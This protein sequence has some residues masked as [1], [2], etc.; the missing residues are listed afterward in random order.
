MPAT[1]SL[2][3]MFEQLSG[4]FKKGSQDT[5][6]LVY[7]DVPAWLDGLEGDAAADLAESAKPHMEEISRIIERLQQN[8]RIL[9]ETE[10][11]G[12]HDARSDEIV[13]NSLIP[14]IREISEP[15]SGN[16]PLN[17]CRFFATAE[18]I[19]STCNEAVIEHG[20]VLKEA[21]PAEI[22]AIKEDTHTIGR[23]LLGAR[24][25]VIEKCRAKRKLIAGVK[26][27]L[28]RIADSERESTNSEEKIALIKNQVL[29][30]SENISRIRSE[31]ADLESNPEPFLRKQQ[32]TQGSLIAKRDEIRKAYMARADI[33][34]ALMAWA[35]SIAHEKNDTYAS[36][37]IFELIQLLTASEVPDA[38]HLMST[39]VC[40]FPIVLD[41]TDSGDLVPGHD[42]AASVLLKPAEFNNELCRICREYAD[43]DA[44]IREIGPK[45]LEQKKQQ[46]KDEEGRLEARL[47]DLETAE[48][49]LNTRRAL[50]ALRRQNLKKP[51]EDALIKLTGSLVQVRL[52]GQAKPGP[53]AD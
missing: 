27:V 25:P 23:A 32:E 5:L 40:A 10:I 15:L 52:N 14:F 37:V 36:D 45:V 34:S 30:I 24:V 19:F 6:V 20:Q 50:A 4:F 29:E 21:F 31:L 22:A 44:Q 35:R 42:E 53:E 7:T 47:R 11:T 9:Q 41:M 33:A 26:E 28:S 13:Q 12:G 48:Q 39:L 16:L 49:D 38:D 2:V 43:M 1:C 8:M 17:T 46:I 51:L 3:T 18:N